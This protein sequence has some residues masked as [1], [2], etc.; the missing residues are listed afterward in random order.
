MPRLF[1]HTE[2]QPAVGS[3][4]KKIREALRTGKGIVGENHNVLVERLKEVKRTREAKKRSIRSHIRTIKFKRKA[5]DLLESAEVLTTL[6]RPAS[7]NPFNDEWWLNRIKKLRGS[8]IINDS[9][10]GYIYF[11]KE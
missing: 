4:A 3:E 9:A 2:T 8:V 10:N 1:H 7:K 11:T 6:D 5:S